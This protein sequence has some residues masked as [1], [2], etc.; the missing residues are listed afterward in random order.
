MVSRGWGGIDVTEFKKQKKENAA[1]E[2][3]EAKE[4]NN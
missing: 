1:K 3:K 4:E 2:S